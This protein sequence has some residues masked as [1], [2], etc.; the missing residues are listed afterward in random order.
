MMSLDNIWYDIMS[1]LPK[2]SLLNLHGIGITRAC[3]L[4]GAGI[5]TVN[6]VSQ[7]HDLEMISRRSGFSLDF[8]RKLQLHAKAIL[9]ESVYQ[10]RPFVVPKGR[11]IFFDIETDLACERIWL[12]G[13]LDGNRFH[14][15]Y[16]HNWKNERR[17][18]KDFL[19]LLEKRRG[20][21]LVTYSGNSF[22]LGVTIRALSRLGING[23]ILG[24]YRHIDLCH[25]LRHGFVFPEKSCGLKSLA[26]YLKYQFRHPDLDGFLV[27]CAYEQHL[28]DRKALDRRFFEYNEDDVR[29][30]PYLLDMITKGRLKVKKR[31]LNTTPI[32]AE[33]QISPDIGN[34]EEIFK[35]LRREGRTL[36]QIADQFGRSIYYVYSRL[37]PKYR[38]M[39]LRAAEIC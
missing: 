29:A 2:E 31:L 22:D 39:K 36:Q 27:A 33:R 4:H 15:M 26:A 25:V 11:L 10:I 35:E 28:R 38:P 17:V 9:E 5:K 18:L 32:D 20:G 3:L 1:S 23:D 13:L 16:S 24:S 8:L 37:D 21:V 19:G 6:D 12:I 14:Q 7:M 30:L 34:E